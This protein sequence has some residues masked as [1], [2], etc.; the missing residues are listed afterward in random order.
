MHGDGEFVAR[1]S[2]LD[3]NASNDVYCRR[4]TRSIE[5]Q[6][7]KKSRAMLKFW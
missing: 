1:W 3:G 6:Q 5:H 7:V 4:E 2:A